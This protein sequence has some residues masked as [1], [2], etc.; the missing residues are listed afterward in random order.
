MRE[1]KYESMRGLSVGDRIKYLRKY[2]GLSQEKLGELIGVSYQQIQ[3]YEK[4]ENK[5][6]VKRLLQIA[7]VLQ[8]SVKAFFE[9]LPKIEEHPP[10]YYR[11]GLAEEEKEIIQY[12]RLIPDKD[13]RA[14]IINLVK[15]TAE[16]MQKNK[17][18]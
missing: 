5:I 2:L 7:S 13:F 4:G 17:K 9:D 18:P 15:A 16:L 11:K 12:L 3:K 14:K 8:V 10:L 1:E 6:N